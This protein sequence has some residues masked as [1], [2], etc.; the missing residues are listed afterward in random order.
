MI[1]IGIVSPLDVGDGFK[2]DIENINRLVHLNHFEKH[3]DEIL[4]AFKEFAFD[5]IEEENENDER[6]GKKS[7]GEAVSRSEILDQFLNGQEGFEDV[8]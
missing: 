4:K 5:D 2:K 1:L 7:G 8:L 3:K 6:T